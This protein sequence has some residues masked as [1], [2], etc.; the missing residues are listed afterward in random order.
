MACK[1]TAP[2]QGSEAARSDWG[3]GGDRSYRSLGTS[4]LTLP[5]ILFEWG[6]WE[7]FEERS[8]VICLELAGFLW[9]LCCK[10]LREQGWK[11]ED[12]L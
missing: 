8:H 2:R 12:S 11:R 1:G 4:V 9:G 3:G 7:A 5:F 10:Q 6:P